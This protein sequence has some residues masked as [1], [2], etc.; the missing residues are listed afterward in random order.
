MGFQKIDF[1]GLSV[2][3]FTETELNNYLKFAV[4]EKIKTVCYGYSLGIIPYIKLFPVIYELGESSELLITDGRPFYLL[5]K[6][7][8]YPVKYEISIPNLSLLLLKIAHQEKY[9]IMLLG[10]TEISNQKASAKIKKDF[11]GAKVL[12]GINGY[13]K[14]KETSEIVNKINILN[15]Q[16]LLIGMSSPKKEVFI[17]NYKNNLTS[18]IIVPCG[19][20]IEV[21]AGNV[22]QAP[23]IIKS[24]GLASF[25]RLLQEPKR[26]FKRYSYIYSFLFFVFLPVFLWKVLIIKDSYFSIPKFCGI[27]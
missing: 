25:Y 9:S 21:L 1:H 10:G 24:L 23:R 5:L 15:P 6:I 7:L 18:S 27:K 3:S 8:K 26:L 14:E 11:P 20:M 12:T 16:I 17:V 22:K 19:G 13:F 4:E 2:S